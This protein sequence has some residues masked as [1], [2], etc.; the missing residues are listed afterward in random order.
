[1][2]SSKPS[3]R[4]FAAAL[5]LASCCDTPA[6]AEDL[7]PHADLICEV[8]AKLA[9]VRFAMGEENTP[10]QF[11]A[12]PAEIDHGLSKRAGAD[13]TDCRLSSSEIRIRVGEGQAFAFG[14]GSANP[15]AFFSLWI[16]HR[17]ILS[18][19]EWKPGYDAPPDKPWLVGLLIQPRKLTYCYQ[20]PDEKGVDCKEEPLDLASHAIDAEEYPKVPKAKPPVGTV[21]RTSS[22]ARAC[23]RYFDAIKT[24]STPPGLPFESSLSQNATSAEHAGNYLLATLSGK[25]A[26]LGDRRVA[27]LNGDN[28]YFDGDIAFIAPPKTASDALVAFIPEDLEQ[29]L[30]KPRPDGWTIVSGGQAALYPD[31]SLRYMHL[32]PEEI[33]G[34]LFFLAYPRYD[35]FRPSGILQSRSPRAA[36]PLS[37]ATSV[38]TRTS[39]A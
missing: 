6:D 27:I 34:Q 32:V 8:T 14:V 11:A 30:K 26:N 19:F 29:L 10:L 24:K 36:S 18:K 16:G 12:L 23:Q 35:D 21:D 5:L 33:E 9:L 39:S 25:F 28:H 4:G 13:R 20:K 37:A 17:K 2:S 31:V 38:S 15:P 3:P 1:V 22:D 7:G